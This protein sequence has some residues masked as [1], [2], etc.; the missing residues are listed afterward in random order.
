MQKFLRK[1]LCLKDN[2]AAAKIYSDVAANHWAI[3]QIGAVTEAGLMTGVGAG[4]FAPTGKV[5]LEQV[6][7]VATLVA[8]VSQVDKAVTG[9]VSP[10]AKGYV[11]AA[12]EAGLLPEVPSYQA[13]ATRG[14]LVE[15]SYELAKPV[16]QVLKASGAK[17]TGAKK[18]TVT[19]N[20]A[21][22]DAEKADLT[23]DVKNG[24]VPYSV[25]AAYAEDK[26]RGVDS[27]IPSSWRLRCNSK[28]K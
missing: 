15:V 6:A 28:R 9:K 13:N 19:F 24:L 3:G 18:I 8:G 27:T 17:Q 2:A 14:I 25:T 7:K 21:V 20:R 11:A 22:T 16:D 23:F 12:I 4:K 5:T 26:I 1:L 10:W